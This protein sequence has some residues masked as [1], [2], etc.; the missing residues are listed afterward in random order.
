MEENKETE[1][2]TLRRGKNLSQNFVEVFIKGI[3]MLKKLHTEKKIC[4]IFQAQ[5]EKNKKSVCS[6]AAKNLWEKHKAENGTQKAEYRNELI[7]RYV[8]LVN[9]VVS[10]LPIT[11]LKGMD[12]DDLI[13]YGTIGLIEAVDRFDPGRNTNFESFAIA[14]IRGSIYDQLRASDLLT[15]GSRKRVKNLLQVSS[16]LEKTLGRYPTDKELAK[17]LLVSL[18][19]LRTIQREAQVAVFSLDEPRDNY[20]DDNTPIVDSI[21]SDTTTL[22]DDLEENELKELLTKAV[23][24]LPEREKIVIG[25]YHYK[26]LTFK[27][28]AEIMDFSESRAS[29]VHARAISLL[30]SKMLK[31]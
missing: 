21:S 24:T 30:K 20:S 15:R 28:I 14:R 6:Q 26:K 12:R 23:A 17:E 25:L 13:G 7:R 8:Y 31:D 9:C 3:D 11:S 1:N 10:R 19:E 27:E 5:E 18:E 16:Q 4:R 2:I 29:Q 22:L